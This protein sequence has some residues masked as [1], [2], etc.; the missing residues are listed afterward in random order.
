LA[1]A[2]SQRQSRRCSSRSESRSRQHA[3][4]P[5]VTSLAPSSALLPP[6][7]PLLLLLLLLLSLLSLG[8]T[9]GVARRRLTYWGVACAGSAEC[10]RMCEC[11]PPPPLL[12][13]L[14]MLMLV[15]W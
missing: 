13:L 3:S 8:A 4:R 15:E 1:T 10:V 2:D 14:L 9:V 6:L 5:W 11:A 12:V 7:P